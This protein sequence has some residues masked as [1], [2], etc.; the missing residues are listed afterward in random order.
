MCRY[1]NLFVAYRFPA[2]CF[3]AADRQAAVEVSRLLLAGIVGGLF[4]TA[5]ST[6]G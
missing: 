6:T 2:R 3:A 4:G 1:G 5:V